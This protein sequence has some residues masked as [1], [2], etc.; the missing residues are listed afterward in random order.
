MRF[1]KIIQT[2]SLIAVEFFFDHTSKDLTDYRSLRRSLYQPIVRNNVYDV[3]LLLEL[4]DAAL[5][6]QAAS[7]ESV[8]KLLESLDYVIY[9]FCPHT[10]RPVI[11]DG[12]T[13][14]ENVIAAPRGMKI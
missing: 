9:N 13:Y 14:S 2:G 1:F 12:S 11:A 5:K 3:L 7:C 10:G 6:F 4:N 8:V